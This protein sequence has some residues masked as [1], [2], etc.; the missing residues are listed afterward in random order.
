MKTKE[1]L[2]ETIARIYACRRGQGHTT[3][4]LQGV[5]P[6]V[7]VVASTFGAARVLR[8][9]APAGAE[10][11][12]AMDADLEARF[13][14][15]KGP[16]LVDNQVFVRMAAEAASV[17]AV[18][19]TACDA[20]AQICIDDMSGDVGYAG[21]ALIAIRAALADGCFGATALE[22]SEAIEALAPEDLPVGFTWAGRA[23]TRKVW[24]DLAAD[25]RWR[26][27]CGVVKDLE[28]E[29]EARVRFHR[30]GTP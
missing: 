16:V 3:A 21:Q 17:R 27:F 7:T 23:V 2:V 13:L 29:R 5:G 1:L 6:G 28:R 15:G 4:L 9:G 19:V 14:G 24:E 25:P 22:L 26:L 12:S 20:L 30:L 18:L 10:F 11:V 8:E